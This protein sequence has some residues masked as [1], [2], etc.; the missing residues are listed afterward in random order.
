M[1]F[2]VSLKDHTEQLLITKELDI[3]SDQLTDSL[4][5]T[6]MDSNMTETTWA[7]TSAQDKPAVGGDA[8]PAPFQGTCNN[9]ALAR[10]TACA[11][12]GTSADCQ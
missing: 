6:N 11:R 9:C 4:H 8:A 12:R 3:T 5:F 10:D 2:R 7:E 1:S